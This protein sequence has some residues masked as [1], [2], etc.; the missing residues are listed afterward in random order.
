MPR[1]TPQEIIDWVHVPEH[2][3]GRA[4]KDI[5]EDIGRLFGRFMTPC[6]VKCLLQR[7][8]VHRFDGYTR[9]QVLKITQGYKSK[10]PPELKT[11]LLS[12]PDAAEVKLIDMLARVNEHF[13][14]NYEFNAFKGYLKRSG[15]CLRGSEAGYFKKGQPSAT[16]GR[17]M[18]RAQYEKCKATMFKKGQVPPTTLPVG[19]VVVADK[20]GDTPYLSVKIAEPNVWEPVHRVVWVAH[21]GPIPPGYIVTFLD[22]NYRNCDISNLMLISRGAHAR[23]NQDHM[24]F[25]G[26]PE[27]TKSGLLLSEV[28]TV[29]HKKRRKKGD[30]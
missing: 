21:K 24:R 27:L 26:N 3:N 10:Y 16:K 8:H 1:K 12:Q 23:A 20:N 13:G 5:A 7:E 14:T 9:K 30:K 25:E 18:T 4:A 19:T 6:A 11:W 29:L 2:V 17:P 22:G 15:I 28:K